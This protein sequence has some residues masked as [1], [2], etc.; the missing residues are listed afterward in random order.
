[1]EH[2]N[3][4][5][6]LGLAFGILIAILMAVGFLGL[7]R[8]DQINANLDD[9]LGKRWIKL[10]LARQALAYSG[11]NSRI[12]MEIFLLDDRALID[13]L[14]AER[15][16]N[17]QNI[18]DLVTKLNAQCDLDE[19]KHLLT[20]IQ[21]SRQPYV[22]SYLKAL[23][24]LI[25]ERQQQAARTVMVAETTPALFKY[26]E[27]WNNFVQFE[28]EQMDKEANQNRDRYKRTRMVVLSLILGAVIVAAGIAVFVT[29]RMMREIKTRMQAEH[30]VKDVNAA[31]EQRVVERTQEL[32]ITEGQ[33]RSSL[34]ELKRY[35]SEVEG[36]NELVELLQ[37]C[38]TLEEAYAQVARVVPRFFPRGELLMQ[39]PS[40]NLLDSVAAWGPASKLPGPFSP[41]SCWAL[42]R[43]R[44]HVAGTGDSDSGPLCAHVD[45]SVAASHFC[46]P[47]VAQ[48][49]S[50]G[51]LYVQEPARPSN[52]ASVQRIQRFSTAL[53]EQMSL[54]FANLML[55]ETLKF[56]SVRDPLTGLFNRRHMEESLAR[57][58]MRAARNHKPVAVLMFDLDHFKRFNDDFG[59]EAG[60]ILLRELGSLL[61]SQ[62][63]G[64][65]V[66]CRYGGEEF[67]II[68][69]EASVDS[70]VRRA[71]ALREQVRNMHIHDRGQTFPQVTVSI[72][73]AGFPEHGTSAQQVISSADKALYRAKTSGRDR[74]I[75]AHLGPDSE[76][77][78][79]LNETMPL[80]IGE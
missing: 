70:A 12:T 20:A 27:A 54:A 65:D 59:H 28:M 8:M 1:L 13:Q 2:R 43:G 35:T 34:D 53:A 18:S 24:L 62:T 42:R 11:R 21:N 44:T 10:Q 57:E 6:K 68:L 32:A 66:A 73:V 58:L 72:G 15:A 49:E 64:G 45:H 7:S 41:D 26:H 33:L 55:R 38:L 79:G 71:E 76:G 16:N 36:V 78:E 9:V 5:T 63:R 67:L 48:G 51:V 52:P 69:V 56:Q 60:D 74:V 23:H 75:V 61:R 22:T 30:A 17:T 40:R 46:V 29:F 4:G 25:D 3:I 77:T 47:M 14:L 31:L 50:L 19:E 80:E 39:N 37:S